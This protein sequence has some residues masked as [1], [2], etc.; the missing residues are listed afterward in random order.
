MYGE[1]LFN[2]GRL[3]WTDENVKNWATC[4]PVPGCSTSGD[5]N[6]MGF[7][8]DDWANI[9]SMSPIEDDL[10]KQYGK[11]FSRTSSC[12]YLL[13]STTLSSRRNSNKI[14]ADRL[15]TT[16]NTTNIMAISKRVYANKPI[17]PIL[18]VP[19]SDRL[20]KTRR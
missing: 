2:P 15:N 10:K 7:N 11:G 3:D 6:F 14:C 17:L 16:L 8:G 18:K 1:G 20:F 12:T 9:V 4:T 13:P 19:Q 5:D